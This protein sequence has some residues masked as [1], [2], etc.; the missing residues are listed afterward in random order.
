M[1]FTDQTSVLCPESLYIVHVTTT[2]NEICYT[3][4]HWQIKSLFRRLTTVVVRYRSLVSQSCLTSIWLLS[5]FESLL[6]TNYVK[7]WD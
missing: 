2:V 6:I 7:D 3:S 5:Q 1:N 4:G